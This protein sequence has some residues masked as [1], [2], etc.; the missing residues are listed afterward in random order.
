MSKPIEYEYAVW[1]NLGGSVHRG[2][3][4]ETE[5]I[6]WLQDALDDGFPATVVKRLWSIRRRPVAEWE[7]Y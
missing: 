1:D 3:W 5:C 6:L 2:P 7:T 4:P